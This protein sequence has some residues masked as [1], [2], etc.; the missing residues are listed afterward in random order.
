VKRLHIERA[1][2]G[3]G[4]GGGGNSGRTKKK[5]PEGGKPGDRK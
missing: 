5:R 3:G 2:G 4:G 1:I